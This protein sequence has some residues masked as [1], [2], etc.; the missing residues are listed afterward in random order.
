VVGRVNLLGI[1]DCAEE[2]GEIRLTVLLR[3]LGEDQV[4]HVRL[5]LTG[6]RRLQKLLRHCVH[7][8]LLVG[9]RL[10]RISSCSFTSGT[11]LIG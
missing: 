2:P 10:L 9:Y 4:L 8:F 1:G 6:E 7:R 5:A 11:S 3:L